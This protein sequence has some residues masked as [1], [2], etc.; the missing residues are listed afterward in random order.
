MDALTDQLSGGVHALS[1]QVSWYLLVRKLF[2]YY[3]VQLVFTPMFYP[4]CELPLLIITYHIGLCVRPGWLNCI[5][6]LWGY[7]SVAHQ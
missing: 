6:L 1:I 5:K 4:T 3:L 7:C 2:L